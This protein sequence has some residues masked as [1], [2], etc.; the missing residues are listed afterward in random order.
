MPNVPG[1]ALKLIFGEMAQILLY[2]S[3]VSCQKIQDK[4]FTFKFPTLS[5]ALADLHK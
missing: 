3:R 5:E 2:G 4:G 1:F